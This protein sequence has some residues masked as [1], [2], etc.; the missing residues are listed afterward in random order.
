M[1]LSHFPLAV[2]G[3]NELALTLREGNPMRVEGIELLV[4]YAES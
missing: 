1:S 3:R 4:E 2:Q